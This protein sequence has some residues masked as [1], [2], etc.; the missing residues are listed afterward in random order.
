MGIKERKTKSR[1]KEK[2]N[3]IVLNVIRVKINVFF[4]IIFGM[5]LVYSAEMLEKSTYIKEIF[6]WIAIM[7]IIMFQTFKPM[8]IILDMIQEFVTRNKNSKGRLS[9]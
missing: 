5:A 9:E 2:M 1:D 6:F 4:I 8:T 7:F 3:K